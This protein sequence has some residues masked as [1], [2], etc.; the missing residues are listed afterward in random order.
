MTLN[1]TH[2]PVRPNF[3]VLIYHQNALW[4]GFNV[5]KKCEVF[6]LCMFIRYNI[7]TTMIFFLGTIFDWLI[8]I[9]IDH[10]KT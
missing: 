6:I 5:L 9:H 3:E 4:E 2:D 7:E 10:L 8:S 1:V